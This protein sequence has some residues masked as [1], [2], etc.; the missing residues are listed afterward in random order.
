L[1][2]HDD[3]QLASLAIH[4][5][6]EPDPQTG[7]VVTPVYQCSTFAFQSCDQ[8]AAR[9]LGKEPGFIYTRMGNP[10]TR[11]FERNVAL[12]EKGHDA[13]ATASGMAAVSTVFFTF[14]GHGDHVVSSEA[15]YG[16]SRG[17]LE[18]HFSRFG[19]DATF[20]DTGDLDAVRAAIRPN[21]KLL[22]VETPANPTLRLTDIAG[23]A[24]IAQT[25][26]ALLVVDNTFATPILQTPLALGADIVLH[27][28]TK[29]INGHAD[30]VGG[31]I[32]PAREQ[33]YAQ[34]RGTLNHLGGTMDPMQS[35]L[36]LRGVKTLSLRVR[37]AQS[38]AQRIAAFLAEHPKVSRVSYPGLPT[39][40]QAALAERQ[41]RGPGALMAFEM[42]GG[43]EAGKRLL[44][45]LELM[46]L[47]VSLGGVE[48]LIQ[49]PA[50]M[51]HAGVPREARLA[52]GIADG[53]VR[54]SVGCEDC[55]DLLADLEQGLAQV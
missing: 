5:G 22:Y 38:N 25:C 14:L 35:W 4:G 17:V 48:T 27:S 8:G 32:V 52:A 15:V 6:Q 2:H 55:G 23:C 20:V 1:S 13:L 47:A 49:H 11:V 29:F 37:A 7:A 42:A 24:E 10:T 28:I 50:G 26:S 43:L 53:L 40:P 21:T 33:E 41:M 19:V 12:L 3:L 31:V 16:P 44:D 36:V 45:S 9:F 54:L 18:R 39:F 51:T 34:L 30:V 46:V